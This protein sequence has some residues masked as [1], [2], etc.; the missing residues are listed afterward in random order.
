MQATKYYGAVEAVFCQ[1]RGAVKLCHDGSYLLPV[2]KEEIQ[3]N[4]AKKPH[5]MQYMRKPFNRAKYINDLHLLTNGELVAELASEIVFTH[6]ALRM[7]ETL[8]HTRQEIDFGIMDAIFQEVTARL[9]E[10][11]K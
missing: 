9:L 11:G 5:K 4:V 6:T 3:L 2:T 8:A 7:A 10:P 1:G